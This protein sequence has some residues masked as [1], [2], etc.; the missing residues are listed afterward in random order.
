[1]SDER[2]AEMKN[3]RLSDLFPSSLYV[4]R[5]LNRL[6]AVSHKRKRTSC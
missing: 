6:F 3:G 2:S 4:R 1:M 5:K